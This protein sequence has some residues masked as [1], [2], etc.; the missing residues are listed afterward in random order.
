[1]FL[2]DLSL[3]KYL[4]IVMHNQDRQY[5]NQIL[6]SKICETKTSWYHESYAIKIIENLISDHIMWFIISLLVNIP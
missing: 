2:V 1:M 3:D 5:I 4:Y 6:Y